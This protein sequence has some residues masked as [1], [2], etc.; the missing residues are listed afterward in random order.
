[1]TTL[2]L[3]I[4]SFKQ[5]N[6]EV[7]STKFRLTIEQVQYLRGLIA[8]EHGKSLTL[9]SQKAYIDD[10]TQQ[11]TQQIAVAQGVVEIL[12]SLIELSNQNQN[13]GE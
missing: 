7:S 4:E 12:E 8:A 3:L 13:I 11:F 9:L 5:N 2:N 10:Y 1:M 6:N